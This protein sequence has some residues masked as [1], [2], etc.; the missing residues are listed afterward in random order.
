MFQ[1]E[2][3]IATSHIHHSKWRREFVPSQVLLH[4][5]C[6][7][8]EPSYCA[9]LPSVE[10]AVDLAFLSLALLAWTS[11]FVVDL[12]SAVVVDLSSAVVVDLSSAVVVDLS[13]AVV[14]D[15][16]SAVVVD[17]SSAVVVEKVW[18]FLVKLELL[19]GFCQE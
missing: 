4:P 9:V 12:S 1:H 15:L 13:S 11:A 5:Y 18:F 10:L 7:R 8:F 6:R 2:S 17:F 16:S 3:I 14:V 19:Q